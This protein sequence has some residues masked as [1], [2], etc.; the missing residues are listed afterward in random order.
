MLTYSVVLFSL[1]S[2]VLFSVYTM[3]HGLARFDGVPVS[4]RPDIGAGYVLGAATFFLDT[5]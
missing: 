4:A 2:E 1:F 5:G 3:L